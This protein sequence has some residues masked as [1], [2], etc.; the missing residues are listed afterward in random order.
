M[1]SDNSGLLLEVFENTYFHLTGRTPAQNGYVIRILATEDYWRVSDEEGASAVKAFAGWCCRVKEDGIHM[2]VN[3]DKLLPSALSTVFHEVGHG[4]H[5]ILNPEQWGEWNEVFEYARRSTD[6]EA[7]V[8]AVA[9]TFE[10]AN[11][12]ILEELTGVETSMLPQG[13]YLAES[14]A[15]ELVDSV[16]TLANAEIYGWE[17]YQR[18]RL[19]IW[20]AVLYD[21]ELSHLR[22]EFEGNGRLSGASMYE[23]FLKLVDIGG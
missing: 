14:A 23:L 17:A 21:P 9:M 8:E 18:G 16:I 10:V 20:T 7:Y 6:L 12:R 3:A 13:Q 2:F 11:F 4:L 5:D 1:H 19:L 22:R 15:Q